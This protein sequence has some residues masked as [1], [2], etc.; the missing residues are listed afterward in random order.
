MSQLQSHSPENETDGVGFRVHG[1]VQN[2]A[3]QQII[4]GPQYL[5]SVSIHNHVS[6]IENRRGDATADMVEG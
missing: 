1:A 4:H 6:T 2:Q 5:G 3:A